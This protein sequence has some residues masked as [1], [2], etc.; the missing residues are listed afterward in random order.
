MIRGG[1]GRFIEVLL[2]DIDNELVGCI[3][4]CGDVLV[5]RLRCISNE[6]NDCHVQIHIFNFSDFTQRNVCS[7]S[8]VACRIGPGYFC[9]C[10]EPNYASCSSHAKDESVN[11][12]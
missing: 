7:V 9:Q 12:R 10:A 11:Y 8:L 1:G 4:L 2:G 5:D 3:V 6:Y